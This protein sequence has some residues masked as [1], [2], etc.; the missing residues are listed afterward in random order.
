[1][2]I[3]KNLVFDHSRSDDAQI[4]GQT[5]NRLTAIQVAGYLTYSDRNATAYLFECSCGG[6][7]VTNAKDVISGHTSSCGCLRKEI[8]AAQ[9]KKNTKLSNTNPAFERYYNQQVSQ[10]KK[11]GL[12][13]S[14]S[15]EQVKEIVT[16]NCHY[17]G[18]APKREFAKGWQGYNGSFICN[19]I[20]RKDNSIGYTYE[21]SLPA[22]GKCN[23]AKHTGTYD[24]FIIW[25]DKLA[26]FRLSIKHTS[27]K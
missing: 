14:L 5:F 10:A 25:I 20:D 26:N 8:T 9:G 4:I 19:G 7:I 6:R 18:Q 13:F 2:K 12:E 15:K 22:C 17:C 1:M 3:S 23:L 16:Q 27:T 11:R 24:D 21:N